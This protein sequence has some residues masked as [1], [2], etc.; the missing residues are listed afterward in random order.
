MRSQKGFTLVEILVALA[1]LAIIGVGLLSALML[2]SKVLLQADTQETARDIAE[3]QIEY[4]QN[5]D[6][7]PLSGN[8]TVMV[9]ASLTAQAPAG[10]SLLKLASTA[11]LPDS[12]TVTIGMIGDSLA[13]TRSY[14]KDSSTSIT[15]SGAISNIHNIGEPVYIQYSPA[16]IPSEQANYAVAITAKSAENDVNLQDITVT[17]YE[18]GV[19]KFTLEG[20]KVKWQ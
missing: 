17:V 3:A 14:I 16:P 15:L 5:Q 9:G 18:G 10:S 1:L 2:A 12:G 4:V 8:I 13:E 11:N 6:F 19:S 7:M 20:K